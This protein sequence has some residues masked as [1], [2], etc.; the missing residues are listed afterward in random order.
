MIDGAVLVAFSHVVVACQLIR[1]DDS[2]FRRL[3]GDMVLQCFS[4]DVLQ[5]ECSGSAVALDKNHDRSFRRAASALVFLAIARTR[6]AANIGFVNFNR[7][8]HRIKRAVLSHSFSDAVRHEPCRLDGNAKL[9]GNLKRANSL[10]AARHQVDRYEPH[11]EGE[12]AV[13]KNRPDANRELLAALFTFVDALAHRA[14]R[15]GLRLQ[16]VGLCCAAMWANRA[17][18][19]HPFFD[20]SAGCVLVREQVGKLDQVQVGVGSGRQILGWHRRD[21]PRL[22]AEI[23]PGRLGFVKYKIPISLGGDADT[24]ACIAGGIAE[25]FYGGVPEDIRVRTLALLDQRLR[26]VVEEFVGR[27]VSAR[28]SG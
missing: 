25:A 3:H 5:R 20:E 7:P 13:L 16:G 23:L 11:C 15:A 4:S 27:F 2:L 8:G 14:C 17:V 18:R 10:L 24:M 9:A 22:S 12:L 28:T 19:P 21:P 1:H 6:L 26:G